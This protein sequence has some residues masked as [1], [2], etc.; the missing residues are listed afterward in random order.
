MPSHH[1]YQRRYC[2]DQV[3]VVIPKKKVSVV[4]T[5]EHG[6]ESLRA[7]GGGSAAALLPAVVK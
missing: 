2:P 5:G 1:L 4:A 6:D 7:L 3:S